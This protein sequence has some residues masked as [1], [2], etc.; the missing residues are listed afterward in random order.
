MDNL[1]TTKSIHNSGAKNLVIWYYKKLFYLF[2][3]LTL[4]NIQQ[5]WIYFSFQHNKII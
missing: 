3:L 2:Y 1:T 4:Q 5:Q